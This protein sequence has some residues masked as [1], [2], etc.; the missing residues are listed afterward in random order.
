MASRFERRRLPATN[1][2]I[3]LPFHSFIAIS[4]PMLI[5]VVSA[6][7]LIRFKVNTTWPILGGMLAGY[8]IR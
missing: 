1:I 2:G 6:V 8:F 7:L 4:N 3:F 5:F